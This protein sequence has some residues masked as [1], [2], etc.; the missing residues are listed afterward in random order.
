[1]DSREFM[2]KMFRLFCITAVFITII[3]MSAFQGK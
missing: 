3:I 1:M 2:L